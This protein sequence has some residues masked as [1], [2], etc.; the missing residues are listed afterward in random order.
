MTEGGTGLNRPLP[1]CPALAP[2]TSSQVANR[3][4]G[5]RMRLAPLPGALSER[6]KFAW[7]AGAPGARPRQVGP[8]CSS[9]AVVAPVGRRSSS[10][11]FPRKYTC[12]SDEGH[13]MSAMVEDGG[14]MWRVKVAL[15]ASAAYDAGDVHLEWGLQRSSTAK[16]YHPKESVPNGSKLHK[17]TNGMRTPMHHNSGTDQYEVSIDVPSRLLPVSLSCSIFL[18]GASK[19]IN[20]RGA[21]H[22][23][24]PV[25]MLPG[26]PSPLGAH[27]KSQ[28]KVRREEAHAVNFAVVSRMATSVTLCLMRQSQHSDSDS[29]E[30]HKGSLEILLDPLVNRTGDVWHV[31]LEGLHDLESLVYG[32][33]AT[34]TVNWDDGTRFQSSRVLLDPYSI[35]AIPTTLAPATAAGG[36]E[37]STLGCLAGLVSE[38]FDWGTQPRPRHAMEQ[39]VA[40]ELDMR[41]LLEHAEGEACNNAFETIQGL[42]PKLTE[43]GI[44]TV[45]LDSIL[46][47]T[48]PSGSGRKLPV[49]YFAPDWELAAGHGSKV[50]PMQAPLE[51]KQ[52][53][54]AMHASGIEVIM[55][56]QYCFTAEGSDAAAV[57]LS[58]RGLDAS[59]YYKA[60]G[61]LNCGHPVVRQLVMDSLKHWVTQY[62]VD[63]FCFENAE[64]LTHDSGGVVQ[65]NPALPED[66]AHDAVLRRCKLVALSEDAGLL[67]RCG[68]RGFPHWGTWAEWNKRFQADFW[69]YLVEGRD[70]KLS[71][72]ATRVTGSADLFAA[73]WDGGLPGSLAAGRR[74][75]FGFNCASPTSGSL[76]S[77]LNGVMP[78]AAE[79]ASGH[80]STSLSLMGSLLLASLTCQGV[81]VLPAEVLW[82]DGLSALVAAVTRLRALYRD[83]LQPPS[84]D[85][86]RS[87]EWH[88]PT[89]GSEPAWDAD[90]TF[91]GPAAPNFISYSVCSS[92]TRGLYVAFNPHDYAVAATAPS[93]PMG[94][95]WQVVS[96][97]GLPSSG[98]GASDKGGPVKIEGGMTLS[99]KS[100]ILL[101]I[102]SD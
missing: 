87:F 43:L 89:A 78:A 8:L 46:L 100:S 2:P 37:T 38:D 64:T 11:P 57:L 35:S 21:A 101:E 74:P 52:M 44:N 84:F 42:I 69:E 77:V 98:E 92:P 68:E 97:T 17:A 30:S 34:G 76:Q 49:S 62:Q 102:A 93:L 50:S 51:M 32:W 65:D 28:R 90:S 1:Q 99:S 83:L 55:K 22:F 73:R 5:H 24:I 94:Y 72:V 15:P 85:A 63:G 39:I 88:G 36:P 27:L 4:P 61:V 81:P 82:D 10:Q 47:S 91:G 40:C 86:P 41:S 16:W 31:C 26:Q 20:P 7:R 48:D 67:P 58:L 14:G 79:P 95:C 70:G 9:E 25:G 33:R 12:R 18:E 80:V 19:Y 3:A 29:E 53:V 75:A 60:N 59:L 6:W 66:L 45:I 54:K 96:Y 23:G 71:N 13:M 56:M